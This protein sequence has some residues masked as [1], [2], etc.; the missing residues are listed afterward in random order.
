M[1]TSLEASA[2]IATVDFRASESPSTG[3]SI[4][5]V[6]D[7]ETV[8]VTIGSV[9]GEVVPVEVVPLDVLVV[10]VDD[11]V[12]LDVDVEEVVPVEIVESNWLWTCALA[13]VTGVRK[14]P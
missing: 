6:G 8:V 14:S 12:P 11:V 4:E 3:C 9:V 2:T 7:E 10:V 13:V 5:T 1:P